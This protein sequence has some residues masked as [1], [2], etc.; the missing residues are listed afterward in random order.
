MEASC[1]RNHSTN[2]K[3]VSLE[4]T[5]LYYILSSEHEK[6]FHRILSVLSNF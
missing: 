2:L 1:K 6:M 5:Y 4:M 3:Q